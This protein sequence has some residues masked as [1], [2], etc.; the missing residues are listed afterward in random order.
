M[1]IE[2]VERTIRH[3]TGMAVDDL[4]DFAKTSTACW[5]AVNNLM[6][7]A[8]ILSTCEDRLTSKITE[9]RDSLFTAAWQVDKGLP[10]NPYGIL[11]TDGPQIEILAVRRNDAQ[12][13]LIA[14]CHL[15]K[16]LSGVDDIIAAAGD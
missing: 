13:R 6:A 8:E 9:A 11:K 14:A 3:G 16:A 2:S 7:A 5:E 4:Q 1:F 12:D 10:V 15:I